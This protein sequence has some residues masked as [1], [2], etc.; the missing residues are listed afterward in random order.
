MYQNFSAQKV[1]FA[2]ITASVLFGGALTTVSLT[3][4]R[5]G[6]IS[7]DTFKLEVNRYL[8]TFRYYLDVRKLT[9]EFGVTPNTQSAEFAEAIPVLL[10]HGVVETPNGINV[11]WSDFKEQMFALKQAGWQT[12]SLSDLYSFL[13]GERKLPEKSFL[14]TFD[15]GR[16]D[17]FYNADPVLK[18]LGY[19]ATI[20]V[21]TKYSINDKIGSRF[22]LPKEK[23]I[24]MIQSGRWEVQSHSRDAHDFYAID[25]SGTK[26]HFFADKLWLTSQN[27]LETNE[28]FHYRIQNDLLLS[29]QDIENRLHTEV[30]SFAF[31]FGDFGQNT[32]DDHMTENLVV[33]EALAV[34]PLVFYQY[35][36]NKGDPLNYP[37][38]ENSSF[39]I[40]RIEVDSGLGTSGLLQKLANY[41]P[42]TLP[43]HMERFGEEW[44]NWWG[45]IHAGKIL[46]LKTTTEERGA[47]TFL[48]GSASFRNYSFLT[49]IDY[50]PKSVVSLLLRFKNGNNYLSCNF[51][52]G[53]SFIEER[54]AGQNR[55]I[56]SNDHDLI[57]PDSD[58]WL[59]ARVNNNSLDCLLG[60]K[61]VAQAS[62]PDGVLESGGVGFKLW[63]PDSEQVSLVIKEIIVT[64]PHQNSALATLPT[65][66]VKSLKNQE[67]GNIEQE[68][69]SFPT[70]KIP[71]LIEFTTETASTSRE[72]TLVQYRIHG[73]DTQNVWQSMY[74]EI[75]LQDDSLRIGTTGLNR[76]SLAVL[77]DS[78]NWSNYKLSATVDWFK[79]ESF[80]LVARYEDSENYA[81]CDY[82][83]Y[84]AY[85]GLYLM[86]EGKNLLLGHSPRLSI[87]LIEPWK[88]QTFSVEVS[89]DNIA[90]LINNDV[91]LRNSL[92]TMPKTGGIGFSTWDREKGNTTVAI[93]S[94][95]VEVI[96]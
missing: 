88:D 80:G 30:T 24:Q 91:I 45:G 19:K 58:L 9:K 47:A 54:L 92:I 39:M 29:K 86:A 71:G 63:H 2:I 37:D 43:V 20:F 73:A 18:I 51:I 17:S 38:P 26:G 14:L 52:D 79:G 90:C 89:G 31:P 84:G 93:K 44:A 36:P 87:P 61:V 49:R 25:K 53:L 57:L 94:I 23:L 75:L 41:H 82:S 76:A 1:F 13:R 46:A 81:S 50:P 77:Q 3:K 60:D 10:Y 11:S 6:N 83:S 21:I 62:F 65:Y 22:Y 66:P 16:K 32:H 27:R 68:D 67:Q 12:I 34:Y 40:K 15:D 35:L 95:V 55:V 70:I 59:G 74:G 5:F 48:A 69:T 56:T 96:K 28:E 72:Q 78:K 4:A 85:V 42:R 7:I 8:D 64:E 33:Q